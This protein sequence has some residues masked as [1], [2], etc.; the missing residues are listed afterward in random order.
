MKMKCFVIVMTLGAM[1]AHAQD[2]KEQQALSSSPEQTSHDGTGKNQIT[3]PE[4][5]SVNCFCLLTSDS[6][7]DIL[8]KE[9][10]KA[11]VHKD[12][13]S[14]AA[15]ERSNEGGCF[16]GGVWDGEKVVRKDNVRNLKLFVLEGNCSAYKIVA[17][18]K[19]I[20][21]IV[22][23]DDNEKDP[24]ECYHVVRFKNSTEYRYIYWKPEMTNKGKI[25][26]TRYIE[27]TGQRYGNQSYLLT[28]PTSEIEAGEYGIIPRSITTFGEIPIVTFGIN[29]E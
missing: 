1:S 11:K 2:V 26:D 15:K 18:D 9:Y 5:E 28:I 14:L 4:P 21:I 6:T 16:G 10:G 7:F 13:N 25:R 27:F 8:P 3:V 29:N 19:D 12:R 22:K 24:L 17:S 20:H 23:A